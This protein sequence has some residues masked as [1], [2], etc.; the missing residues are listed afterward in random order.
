MNLTETRVALATQLQASLTGTLWFP[1]RPSG[2]RDGSGWLVLTEISAEGAT[3]GM[4]R[5]SFN[6]VLAL[7]ADLTHAQTRIDELIVPLHDACVA[8]GGWGI[9][10]TPDTVTIGG[11]EYFVLAA[12]LL[13]DVETT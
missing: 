12:T 3:F 8:T 5:A 13:L 10:V 1:M 4:L 11:A 2:V 9:K 7:G 6:A